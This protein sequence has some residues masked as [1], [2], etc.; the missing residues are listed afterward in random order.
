MIITN[1]TNTQV[2]ATGDVL[3]L[4]LVQHYKGCDTKLNG[5]SIVI[6][7]N[8]VYRI[9]GYITAETTA[10]G[11]AAVSIYRDGVLIP[12]A[13]SEDTVAAGV[14]VTL[15][16]HTSTRMKGCC[17]EDP[18]IITAVWTGTPGTVYNLTLDVG[19]A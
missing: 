6:S 19:V 8:G 2:V 9:T 12:G 18:A 11:T 17:C 1:N 7:G 15:P 13:I 5:N 4:G 10:A 3:N 14:D 16:I